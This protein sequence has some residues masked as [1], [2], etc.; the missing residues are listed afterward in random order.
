MIDVSV[1]M[2]GRSKDSGDAAG[3]S[4]MGDTLSVSGA[5]LAG[6]TLVLFVMLHAPC[7]CLRNSS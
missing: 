1:L 4:C 6:G 5:M 3:A 7:S 2:L